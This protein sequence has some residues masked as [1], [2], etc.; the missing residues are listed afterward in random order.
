VLASVGSLWWHKEGVN[1]AGASGAIFG[2]FGLFLALLTSNLIPKAERDAQLK[3][4]GIFIVYN[5]VYGMKSGVDNSAHVGGLVSGFVI[6]YIYMVAIKK[7]RQGLK[8]SWTVLLVVLATVGI[9][10]AF[11]QNNKV[12]SG[13]RNQVLHLVKDDSKDAEEFN[14]KYNEVIEMQDKALAVL[15]DT[16]LGNEAM[17]VKLKEISLP[18]W[19]K[20]EELTWKMQ[21]LNVS[22][23]N[24][25]K[26]EDLLAYISLRKDEISVMNMVLDQKADA[27]VKL[28]K[29]RTRID[30]VVNLL[31]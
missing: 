1:S 14:S 16:T 12:D 5:L 7:E 6:G 20:A 22:E 18:L 4:I 25:K 15:Q 11:L 21:K 19:E 3:T 23:A 2:L 8:A 28:I 17:K 9:S 29:T 26:A 30:S 24:K 27:T 10:Y 13:T 31:K